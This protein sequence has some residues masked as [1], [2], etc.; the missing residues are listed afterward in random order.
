MFKINHVAATALL[1]MAFVGTAGS[2]FAAPTF[3]TA[4]PGKGMAINDFG[5]QLATFNA[6]DVTDLVAAKTVT[7]IKFQDAWKDGGDAAKSVEMMTKD[8]QAIG[9]LREAL[10]ANPAAVKLLEEN[11]ITVDSV[12]DIVTDGAGNI[13][14]YVA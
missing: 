10:K 2:A 8:S 12:V 1:A 11:K 3:T 6:D 14:L 13:S 7:V 5:T 4:E 9:Q